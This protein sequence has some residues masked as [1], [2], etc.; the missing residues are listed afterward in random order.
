MI[1]N[2]QLYGILLL[3]LGFFACK[4]DDILPPLDRTVTPRTMAQF[5]QNNY[6]YTL[7]RYALDKVGLMDSL[8]HPNQGTFFAPD[9][10]AFNLSGVYNKSD[11]DKMNADSLRQEL[12]SYMLSQRLFVSDMPIQMGNVYTTKSGRTIYLSMSLNS[13][14]LGAE[15]RSLTIN[16]VVIMG[17]V[18]V[19]RNIALTN[20]VI[21]TPKR[22]MKYGKGS[23]QDYIAADTSLSFFAT[24]M[25]QFG[26]WDG[27]KKNNPITV[28]APSNA[29]FKKIGISMD[30]LTRITPDRFD[31][32]VF[33]IYHFN[34]SP[35]R[36]F[37]SDGWL[38]SNLIYGNEGIKINDNGLY[39]WAPNYTYSFYDNSETWGIFLYKFM[40]NTW[41][42]NP[43]GPNSTSYEGAIIKDND[44]VVDNGVVHVI[45]DLLLNPQYFKK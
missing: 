23:A 36:I 16:G 35:K 21:H 40:N 1:R 13:S 7:L 14:Y 6:N 32:L 44:H 28:F 29:A 38:I 43:S 24:A 26:F 27:L 34:F 22:L 5:I 4:K 19:F 31:A 20:G 33:G 18:D 37:S 17:G 15:E 42:P 45:A 2:K 41:Y 12:K 39:S 8:N 11:F 10:N 3:M 25:K 9:N 30:S